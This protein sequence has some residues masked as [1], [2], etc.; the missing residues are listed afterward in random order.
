MTETAATP[1]LH[2][3]R[4]L[5]LQGVLEFQTGWRIGSGSEGETMSDLGIVLDPDGLPLLPGSSLKGKLR[6]TCEALAHALRLEACLLNS[7]ASGKDCVSDVRL[8]SQL[9][10]QHQKAVRDGV[11]AQLRWIDEHTCDVCKLFGSPVRAARLRLGDGRLENPETVVVR[12]R[13]GVVLD[14]DSHTAVNGLKYDYEVAPAGTRFGFRFDLEN[15]TEADL[16]LLGAAL[17]EWLDGSS[18][19]GFTSRGLGR[20]QLRDNAVHLSEID[21]DDD[22]QRVRYLTGTKPDQRWSDVADWKAF[23]QTAIRNTLARTN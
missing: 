12:V 14:R 19:G 21:F 2:L 3:R 16:A 4:R 7:R 22:A 5:R 1:D 18:L 23:F 8:F 20:F 13:D 10:P 6:N 11:A 15:P 17:F 9:R